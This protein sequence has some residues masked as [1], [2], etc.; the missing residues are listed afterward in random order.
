MI[1]VK[2]LNYK[3]QQTE[4][5]Q[6]I[7]FQ[8]AAYELLAVIGPN[9]AGK[10][11]LLKLISKELPNHIGQVMI[12]G[13]EL[14]GYKI[15][16]LAKFRAVLPQNNS[17]SVNLR[18]NDIVMMGRYPHF[19]RNPSSQDQEIVNIYLEELG[20]Q[21]YKERLIYTLSG[22]EQQ[23]VHL[24]RILAQIHNQENAILL[25]DEPINGLDLQYQQI[26][27]EKAR[28]MA[29]AGMIVI[30]ILHD[31]NLAAQYADNILLLENGKI[32]KWGPP[33]EVL[34]EE[35]IFSIY[36]TKVRRINDM[37]LGYPGILPKN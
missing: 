31:I 21:A 16:E 17:M 6:N 23:R 3:I 7:T 5:L 26:I 19:D 15:N 12:H 8:A 4:I 30:C 34:S 28:K 24:A 29:N 2:G 37:N 25:M 36:H 20:L 35:T 14:S 1:E 13:K 22:G 32:K 33:K 9:G 18:V 27:L 11:S 10:S